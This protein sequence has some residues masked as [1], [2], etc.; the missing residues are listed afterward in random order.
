MNTN[1]SSLE[2]NKGHMHPL[3]IVIKDMISIFNEMGFE[4]VDGPEMEEEWYNF[5]ALNVPSYHPARDMQDT[6]WLKPESSRKLLRTHTSSVQIR[7]MEKHKPPIKIISVGKVF[8]NEATDATHEAQFHQIECLMID[9]DISVAHL[10]GTLEQFFEKFFGKKVVARFRPS[11]FL[12]WSLVLNLICNVSNVKEPV[13]ISA[14]ELVGLSLE[15]PAWYIQRFLK[16]LVFIQKS[17]RVSPL[18]MV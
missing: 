4:S 10:K 12:F 9:K 14:R 13:A 16:V 3:S 5:D 15:D 11:Y 2:E 18:A 17:I 6:F 7:Y 8:R 1:E